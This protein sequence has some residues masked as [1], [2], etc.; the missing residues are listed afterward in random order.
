MRGCGRGGGGGGGAGGGL[1]RGHVPRGV[2]RVCG[3]KCY[4]PPHISPSCCPGATFMEGAAARDPAPAT[5]IS[6]Y[7]W[8]GEGVR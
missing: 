3:G 2:G 8:S 1:V 4:P 6:G 5:F 7:L